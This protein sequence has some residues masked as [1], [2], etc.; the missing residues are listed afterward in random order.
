MSVFKSVN[1]CGFELAV[2]SSLGCVYAAADCDGA[3]YGYKDFP[4]PDRRNGLWVSAYNRE[5]ILPANMV[6]LKRGEWLKT[7]VIISNKV[8]DID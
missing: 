2:M 5:Q 3:I 8:L 7:L 6:S 1:V 4:F